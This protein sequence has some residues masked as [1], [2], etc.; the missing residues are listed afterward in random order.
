MKTIEQQSHSSIFREIIVGNQ[1]QQNGWEQLITLSKLQ[2]SYNEGFIE[3]LEAKSKA[4]QFY[5]KHNL[6]FALKN[7]EKFSEHLEKSY[8]INFEGMFLK[9]CSLEEFSILIIL[10]PKD[11][12]S[13]KMDK[14]YEEL[15]TYLEAIN[16]ESKKIDIVFTFNSDS[17]NGDK[18][19]SNGFILQYKKNKTRQS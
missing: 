8:S 4:D 19:K 17:I 5:L 13:S 2:E 7:A 9:I 1:G 10:N 6:E 16:D 12:F 14:V 18:L 11:Y 3:G 15:Y